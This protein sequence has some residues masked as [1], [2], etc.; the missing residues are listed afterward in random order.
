[1]PSTATPFAA[2]ARPDERLEVLFEEL[3]ALVGQRNAI[4]GRNRLSLKWIATNCAV[5]PR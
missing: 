2:E 4:D 5:P 1:M 3:A